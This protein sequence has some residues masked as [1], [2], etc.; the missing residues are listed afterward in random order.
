MECIGF[1]LR[2][3]ASLTRLT[4]DFLKSSAIEGSVPD[5]EQMRSSIARRLG[6]R[7]STQATP[8]SE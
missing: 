4:P 8:P 2:S 6:I 3:E 5:A 7:F 1:D